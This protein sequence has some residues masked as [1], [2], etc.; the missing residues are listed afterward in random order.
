MSLILSDAV[1]M[2]GVASGDDLPRH[3]SRDEG[4]VTGEEV[5]QVPRL[6]AAATLVIRGRLSDGFHLTL[7]AVGT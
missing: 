6:E 1:P 7:V 2:N 3:P 4:L 5:G